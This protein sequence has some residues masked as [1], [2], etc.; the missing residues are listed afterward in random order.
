MDAVLEEYP[1]TSAPVPLKTKRGHKVR[2]Q[3]AEGYSNL[4]SLCITVA[5]VR[6]PQ[7][8]KTLE[9]KKLKTNK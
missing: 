7:N 8:Q 4:Y 5:T 6:V 3:K 9:G 2:M 1:S